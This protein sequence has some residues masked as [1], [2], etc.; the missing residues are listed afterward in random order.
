MNA[1]SSPRRIPRFAVVV[2]ATVALAIPASA[3]EVWSVLPMNARGVDQVTAETFRDLL[4]LELAGLTPH[5]FL[6]GTSPC[7]DDACAQAVGEA[8]G[9]DVVVY[10]SLSA[11][12]EEVIAAVTVY[13]VAA[14]QP[15]GADRLTAQRVEELDTIAERLA[16]AIVSGVSAE[17]TAELGV[18]IEEESEAPLRREGD[19][20][21]G[22]RVGGFFPLSDHYAEAGPGILFDVAFWFETLDFVIEPRIGVRFDTDRSDEATYFEFPID[23][24]GYYVLGRGDFAGLLGGGIGVHFISESR[25]SV[26]GTRSVIQTA[27]NTLLD[28]PLWGFNFLRTYSTRLALTAEYSITFAELNGRQSPQNVSVGLAVIF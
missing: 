14:G 2:L 20:G 15:R 9:A 25:P 22:L 4:Q 11:L 23:I 6:A 3:Q 13:D 16:E 17:E 12:G 10:G 1:R 21:F 5:R 7:A 8:V 27:Q 26:Q 24:G 28:D 19:N 18:I